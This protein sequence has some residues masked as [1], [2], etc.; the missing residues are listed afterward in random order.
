MWNIVSFSFWK[1]LFDY[2][3]RK[4]IKQVSVMKKKVLQKI[5]SFQFTLLS[6]LL[7]ILFSCTA[8][9][10]SRTIGKGNTGIEVTIGGPIMKNLGFPIPIPNFYIGGRY[11]IRND[12]DISANFN[13]LTPFTPGIPL[14]LITAMH[15]MP[16]Q[17]GIRSQSDNKE[18][19]WS[20][21]GT[22]SF[23]WISDFKSGLL[24]IPQLD[25]TEGYRIKWFSFYSGIG[26][27]LNFFRPDNQGPVIQLS[28]YAGLESF[29]RNNFTFGI[30][31]TAYDIL[32]NYKGSQMK[33]VYISDKSDE[34]KRYAPIGIAI[35]A[36]YTL[37][38][39]SKFR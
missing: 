31:C 26:T 21:G 16:V 8:I 27:G 30:K 17:P 13:L 4:L 39:K 2:Q 28:P 9:N 25:I 18:I 3:S 35:G 23:Q 19:G 34:W 20:A 12:L 33:W 29:T 38:K 10:Q 32:Y 7:T 1:Y 24:V 36:G 5:S 22:I 6:I 37:K 14:D 15:W 11:G